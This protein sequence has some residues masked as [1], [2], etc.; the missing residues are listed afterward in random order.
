MDIFTTE[1]LDGILRLELNLPG[2]PINKISRSVRE[3]LERLLDQIKADSSVRAVVLISGK[4]GSFLDGADI[5]EFV[6]LQK[7]EDAWQLVHCGQQLVN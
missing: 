1:N 2:A 5:D 7:R 3:E 4:P 6:A